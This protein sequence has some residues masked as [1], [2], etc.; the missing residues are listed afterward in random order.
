MLAPNTELMHPRARAKVWKDASDATGVL[1]DWY[2][3]D[4]MLGVS[5]SDVSTARR[6][7]PGKSMIP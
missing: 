2:T 3:R 7:R 5:Q 1:G 4:L 6:V